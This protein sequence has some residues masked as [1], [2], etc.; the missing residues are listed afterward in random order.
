MGEAPVATSST[1]PRLQT[2]G[3]EGGSSPIA[4]P[5]LDGAVTS[6]AA[7]RTNRSPRFASGAFRRDRHKLEY[8]HWTSDG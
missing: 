4:A 2:C 3:P 1:S 6:R 7:V 5:V 8:G